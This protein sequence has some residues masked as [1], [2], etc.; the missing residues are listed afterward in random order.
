MKEFT[1]EKAN[2]DLNKNLQYVNEEKN[3]LDTKINDLTSKLLHGW[4]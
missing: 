1:R 2:T 4:F 3:N